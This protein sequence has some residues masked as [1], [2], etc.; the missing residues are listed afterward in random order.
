MSLTDKEYAELSK[1][2]VKCSTNMSWIKDRLEK[3]DVSFT[4]F[5]TRLSKI[6]AEHSLMKGKLGAFIAG[7][8][9]IATLIVNGFIWI[10]GHFWS[11]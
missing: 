4:E 10:F 8:T 3:G 5:N 7:L 9:F 6:E 1:A 11:K 2:I